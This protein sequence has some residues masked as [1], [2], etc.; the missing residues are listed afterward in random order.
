MRKI[1]AFFVAVTLLLGGIAETNVAYAEVTPL[2]AC[3][4]LKRSILK[5]NEMIQKG[6]QTVSQIGNQ[7]SGL[8][9]EIFL[10]NSRNLTRGYKRERNVKRKR[11]Y[12]PRNCTQFCFP[13]DP[14]SPRFLIR[15]DGE[16]ISAQ[17]LCTSGWDPA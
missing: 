6:D 10:S 17:Y 8:Q 3:I 9:R 13:Y 12:G 4:R 1:W 14:E 15:R 5:L 7:M 11:F 2:I 16:W